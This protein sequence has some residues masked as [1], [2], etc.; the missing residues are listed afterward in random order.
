MPPPLPP[1]PATYNASHAQPEKETEHGT[2]KT[3]K[4]TIRQDSPMWVW[5]GHC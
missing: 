4:P 1:L 3:I 2:K 5:G